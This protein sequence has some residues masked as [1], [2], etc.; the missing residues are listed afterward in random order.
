MWNFR[1]IERLFFEFKTILEKKEVSM[2]E[3]QVPFSCKKIRED[4]RSA[5]GGNWTFACIVFALYGITAIVVQIPFGDSF[6]SCLL[7]ILLSVLQSVL[8]IGFCACFL[9]VVRKKPLSCSRLFLG[10]AS[11]RFFGKTFWTG[12]L[13]WIFI[14]LWTLLLVV[15]GIIKAISYSLVYFILIDNPEYSATEAITKSREMMYGHKWELCSLFF[16]F[17]G[18]W[19]LCVFTFGIAAIWVTP[20]FMTAFA[21]FYEN[22]KENA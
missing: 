7:S 9:D 15:P 3:I 12:L 5:L 22:L 1:Q 16:S 4:A 10:Y 18:W 8:V 17:I 21:K 6:A 11:L 19:L 20:Y 14:F 2:T 13:A